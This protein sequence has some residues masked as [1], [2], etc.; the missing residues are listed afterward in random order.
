MSEEA[1]GGPGVDVLVGRRIGQRRRELEL[2]LASVAERTGLD[3]D[4]LRAIEE[5]G[6]SAS[7]ARLVAIAKALDTTVGWL[8]VDTY[9]RE[10]MARYGEERVNVDLAILTALVED[11]TGEVRER[12][13]KAIT[14]S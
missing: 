2:T 3:V 5:N 8:F 11:A 13:L 6:R 7:P 4:E 9:T 1:T 14:K 10:R 12:L